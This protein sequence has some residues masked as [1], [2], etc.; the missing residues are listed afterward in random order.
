M[1]MHKDLEKFDEIIS[2]VDSLPPNADFKVPFLRGKGSDDEK[3]AALQILDEVNDVFRDLQAFIKVKLPE[4]QHYLTECQAIDFDTEVMGISVRTN[5][6]A[7]HQSAWK[8]GMFKLHNL[9]KSIRS[10]IVLQIEDSNEDVVR[11]PNKNLQ[12]GHTQISHSNV[13]IGDINSSSIDYGDPAR[14]NNYNMT[15]SKETPNKPNNSPTKTWQKLGIFLA[16]LIGIASIILAVLMYKN[17]I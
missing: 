10:E 7:H 3:S 6:E 12:I 13:V 17:L 11:R 5:S 1:L 9:L 8:E 4:S 14:N 2:R 15:H 16:T